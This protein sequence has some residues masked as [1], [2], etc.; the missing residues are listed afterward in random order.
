MEQLKKILMLKI[1]FPQTEI[2]K[3]NKSNEGVTENVIKSEKES[4]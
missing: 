4:N 3:W 2:E 1:Q